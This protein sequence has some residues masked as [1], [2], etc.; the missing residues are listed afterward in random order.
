MIY[1]GFVV[2]F[3]NNKKFLCLYLERWIMEPFY[4][5]LF[6]NIPLNEKI[7]YIGNCLEKGIKII[8]FGTKNDKTVLNEK[9]QK[10]TVDY[11]LQ[12]YVIDKSNERSEIVIDGIGVPILSSISCLGKIGIIDFNTF[13]CSNIKGIAFIPNAST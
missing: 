9:F 10:F 4:S 2:A 11:F 3:R 12:M 6:Y 8:W 13:S 1:G 7:D 5:V